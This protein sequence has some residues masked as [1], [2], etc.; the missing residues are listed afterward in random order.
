M[1][2]K[3][4]SLAWLVLIL[5]FFTC[6]TL[7]I[8]IPMAIRQFILSSVRPLTIVL[9]HRQGTVTLQAPGAGS[10]VIV[11]GTTEVLPR[12]HIRGDSDADA[13]LLFYQPE[14]P[15]SPVAAIQLYGTTSLVVTGA[16]TPRFAA[17]PLPHRIQMQIARARNMHA[18]IFGNGR[19]AELL[20]DTPQGPVRLEEG[21]FRLDVEQERTVLIVNAGRAIVTDP[22]TETPQ[23]LVPLQRTE[24]TAAGVGEIYVGARDLLS[25]RNGSFNEPLE[26]TWTV[27][28]DWYDVDEDGGA[29]IQT[30][31]GDDQ[32]ILT[33]ERAGKSHAETGIR[34]EINQD[35][36]EVTSLQIRARVRI[37]TQTLPVCG[38]VG[39][40]CPI[41]LRVYYVDQET[42]G[43]REWL[44]GFY[45][46]DGETA[47]F[48]QICRDWKPEHIKIPQDVWYD[49]ESPDLLPLLRAQG[50][51]PAA[52]QVIEV[53]AS[54]WTYGSAIDE[55]AIL[56]G[57]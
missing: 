45:A 53:Y 21:A 27:Y 57:D 37:S 14:Q 30:Q 9:Q 43:I 8:G 56:V 33:F 44:Q 40:E 35:I 24:I 46:R 36:R 26:G 28:R 51:N 50:I 29:V 16:R 55:V 7:T 41:M 49:Y 42:G 22:A 18:S 13:L 12:S 48:C 1:L 2:K 6:V 5:A 23:V 17:S 38:S 3:T 15:E 47:P 52:L 19:E 32:R 39:T 4:E 31:L 20:T 34:Q 25:S 10:P 54:G 11:E